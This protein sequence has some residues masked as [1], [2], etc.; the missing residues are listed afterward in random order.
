MRIRLP[1]LGSLAACAAL[2]GPPL[3]DVT[4]LG[5]LGGRESRA[6]GVSASGAVC[7]EAATG[8]GTMHAFVWT[9]AAGMRDLGTLGGPTSRGYGISD[10]GWVVG[11]ADATNAQR[12]PFCWSPADGLRVLPL[13]PG[14]AGGAALAVS[15]NG[16]IAGAVDLPDGPCAA[17]W[18]SPTNQPELLTAKGRAGLALAVSPAGGV[19]GQS[20]VGEGDDLVTRAF[21]RPPEG[22]VAALSPLGDGLSSAAR[23]IN[24]AGQIAG[25]FEAGT[26]VTHAFVFD[27]NGLRDIDARNNTF[28]E[29]HAINAAGDVVGV[30]FVGPDDGDTAFLATPDGLFLL[31]DLVEAKE[32]WHVVEARAIADDRRIAGC[33]LRDERERAVLL[34]PHAGAAPDLPAVRLIAP[35]PGLRLAP[36][37]GVELE[38]EATARDGVKRVSFLA[39]GIVIGTATGAPFRLSWKDVPPGEIDLV[40]RAVARTGRGNSSSRVRIRSEL[41]PNA[42]PIV[43][44][45]APTGGVVRLEGGGL[46]FRAEARD[47]DG[48]VVGMELWQD[49]TIIAAAEGASL[50]EAWS[51]GPAEVYEFRV[52][53]E[54]ERGGRGTSEVRRVEFG[55]AVAPERGTQALPVVP[56]AG[57]AGPSGPNADLKLE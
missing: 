18:L 29:A 33:A 45:L 8:E 38:A 30:C 19:V 27:A 42:V 16:Q 11:E 51:G 22:V 37:A 25:S 56:G 5:A 4:D 3:Y 2:A 9:A 39:N 6:Y 13:P 31:D 52:V 28:S 44:W 10:A 34:T 24:A 15:S 12:Q 35:A 20:E 46:E 41:P 48:R 54:D 49:G 7:G 17:L 47:P 55:A 40:A 26:G 50:Q 36:G 32:A 43:S 53:A 57:G 1:A 14:A 23:A 21:H